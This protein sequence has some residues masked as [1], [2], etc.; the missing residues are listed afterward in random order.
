MF[1]P[2]NPK[3]P[4]VTKQLSQLWSTGPAGHLSHGPLRQV[5]DHRPLGMVQ[6]PPMYKN[7]DDWGMVN[8]ALFYPR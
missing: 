4:N 7:G 3:L 2:P 8:M 1:N 6:T 5:G